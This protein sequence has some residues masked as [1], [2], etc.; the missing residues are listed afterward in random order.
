MERL[1]QALRR[2]GVATVEMALVL[3]LLLML[4]FGM[5][6]YGWM[7]LKSQQVTNAARQGARIAAR[8]DATTIDTVT[9]IATTME[10]AG[11]AAS[12][13]QVNVTPG[14]VASLESG[15]LLTVA[16]SVPYGNVRLLAMPLIPTPGS[17]QASTTMAKEGP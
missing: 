3:P 14:D 8:A 12:G 9:S 6:E 2:R 16:V 13:Y 11:L 5:I 1:K 4:T 10:D 7:F 15:Q 17:L